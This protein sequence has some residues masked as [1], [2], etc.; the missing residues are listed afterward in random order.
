MNARFYLNDLQP[1]A[2]FAQ[3]Q[4]IVHH[5]KSL[6]SLVLSNGSS[7]FGWLLGS[8]PIENIVNLLT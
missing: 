5:R 2:C 4:S 1:F 6:L 8:K 7:C 3:D